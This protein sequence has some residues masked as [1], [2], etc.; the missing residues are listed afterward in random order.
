MTLVQDLRDLGVEELEIPLPKI[1]VI[2][3]QS[4]G[5]SSLIEGISGIKVPRNAGTCTRCPLEIN[6]KTS[7]PGDAWKCKIFLHKTYIYE[8]HQV[9]NSF[10]KTGSI[11]SEGA[12]RA[13][14][15][16]P[17]LLQHV[18]EKLPFYETDRKD[19]IP[20]ALHLAQLA[21]LNPGSDPN[22]FR[23]G[24]GS[25]DEQ[26]QVK[27]SPNVIKVDI[28]APDVPNLSFYE[29]VFDLTNLLLICLRIT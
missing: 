28:S 9:S 26:F 21:T 27:F 2:G 11:K 13:R 19:D 3:D 23:P 6:L 10:G 18:P 5:K 12:T 14:P 20:Q 7:E 25:T 1:C 8:G 16:G 17:W 15:L 22:K 4:T 24:R 29:Y